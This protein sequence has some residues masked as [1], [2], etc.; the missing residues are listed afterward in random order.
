MRD[1]L[2]GMDTP[3]RV[4][5][6]QLAAY[7]ARDIEAWLATYDVQA[8]QYE[9]HGQRV[10]SGHAEIRARGQARF[11]EPDLH[12]QL[13][14]RTVMGSVVVDYERVTRNFPEGRGT[15][16][17]LCIYEVIGST[18]R[19]ASFAMGARHLQA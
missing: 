13:L 10:A 19:K 16:E 7:N 11:A 17:M 3:E 12:A 8:E 15:V 4:V 14:S 1:A 5:Q 2:F 6:R 9:L 18:I